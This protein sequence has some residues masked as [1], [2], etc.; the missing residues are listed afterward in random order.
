MSSYATEGA[1][2][3]SG[4]PATDGMPESKEAPGAVDSAEAPEAMGEPGAADARNAPEAPEDS[5]VPENADAPEG[6]DVP[7]LEDIAHASELPP[8]DAAPVADSPEDEA[9]GDDGPD[10]PGDAD[11][12]ADEAPYRRPPVSKLAV[13]SLVMGI[14]PVVPVALVTGVA[15][16]VGIRRSGRRGHGMAVTALFLAAA[17][18]IVGGAVGTVAVLTHG[19]KKPVK[20]IYHEEAVFKLRPG[21]CIDIPNGGQPTVVSCTVPHDAE[22]FGAFTLP[23]SAWPGTAAVR[24][25]AGAGCGT[26]LAT[27]LNPQ[28]AISLAQTYV[29]PNQVDWTAGTRTVI[30]EVQA[31]SGQLSQSVRGGS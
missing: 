31:A 5:D 15:A 17:W 7:A 1:Q 19:F 24:Q 14:L 30:C 23:G 13:F 21:E 9:D 29:Y 4:D 2:A 12:G 6:A 27:Y 16:L 3:S 18:I 11:P 25:E 10:N 20:T 22:V 8:G 28:L 26:R